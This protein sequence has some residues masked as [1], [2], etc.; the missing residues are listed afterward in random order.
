MKEVRIG[1][2]GVGQIGKIHL[3]EYKDMEGVKVVAIADVDPVA[4]KEASDYFGI[5]QT[6]SDFREML[7]AD[8]VDAVDICLHNNLHMPF[9]VAALEAGKDVFC[10]KPMAGAYVDAVKMFETAKTCGRM[11][12]IQLGTLFDKETKVAKH[13]ID[14][15][16]LGKVFHARSTGFRR[17]GRPFVDGYGTEQFV[18]KSCFGRWVVND[19]SHRSQSRV[20]SKLIPRRFM[21]ERML[22]VVVWCPASAISSC[23]T[24]APCVG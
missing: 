17:R 11:L 7:A 6:Y 2:I 8:D 4:L 5:E 21:C 12:S 19:S 3:N 10:E 22:S 16:H 24:L 18:Q 15:G 1:M 13:L 23:T 9:T 14:A 20:N